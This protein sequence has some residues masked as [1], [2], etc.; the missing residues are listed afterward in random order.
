MG[1]GPSRK[2]LADQRVIG[3]V[4]TLLEG[5]KGGATNCRF[6]GPNTRSSLKIGEQWPMTN[7]GEL[8]RP[9]CTSIKV[10]AALRGRRKLPARSGAGSRL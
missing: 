1:S 10:T 3:N 2:M 8:S 5:R 4:M 6:G 7:L 9:Q